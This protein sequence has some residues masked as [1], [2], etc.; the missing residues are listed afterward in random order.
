MANRPFCR[1]TAGAHPRLRKTGDAMFDG[2]LH[3]AA[4][5]TRAAAGRL[6]TPP[7]SPHACSTVRQSGLSQWPYIFAAGPIPRK[8]APRSFHPSQR[9][10]QEIT[11]QNA[12]IARTNRI[13]AG[14]GTDGIQAVE[15]EMRIDLGFQGFQ[16]RIARLDAGLHGARLN[17]VRGFL[18]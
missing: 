9:Q 2:V 14:Q 13:D 6:W 11:E 7:E 1:C 18:G 4:A 17:F 5:A 10:P 8:G 3:E 12:H 15:Q 16:L